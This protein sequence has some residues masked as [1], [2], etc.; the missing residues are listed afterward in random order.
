[1]D[2]GFIVWYHVPDRIRDGIV[3]IFFQQKPVKLIFHYQ[4]IFSGFRRFWNDIAMTF[5]V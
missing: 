4:M 5:T 3:T 1:M 2:S